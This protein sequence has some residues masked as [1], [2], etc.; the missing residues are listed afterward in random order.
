MTIEY[1]TAILAFITAIYAYLT[2]RMTQAS[3]ASVEVMREQSEALMRPYI[4]VQP[5]V[6]SHT[7]FI[8]LRI[9]NTGRT[10]A[11]NLKLSIDRDF[12]QYGKV[13]QPERNLRKLSAFSMPIDTFPP[14]TELLFALGQSWV[15]FGNEE[16]SKKC[17]TQ[18]EVTVDFNLGNKDFSESHKIDLRPYLG[19][20]GE[21][22]P[23]VGEIEKN[24]TILEKQK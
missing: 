1:L 23:L 22:D 11:E 14:E 10:G 2:H 15:I 17:P 5:F 24:R 6:R 7:P 9:K 19:C 13:K 16:E 18:F 3:E 21:R 8:Y 12:F 4:I 20:E